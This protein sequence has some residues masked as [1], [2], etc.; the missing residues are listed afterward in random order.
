MSDCITLSEHS[1]SDFFQQPR[2]PGRDKH[3]SKLFGTISEEVVRAW[4]TLPSVKYEDKGRP[5][6]KRRDEGRGHT[7]DF[8]LCDRG[9]GKLYI[10]ELKCELEYENYRYLRLTNPEQLRHHE[11]NVAAFRKFVEVARDPRAIPVTVG[12]KAV[13]VS[14][15]I[16]IWGAASPQGAEV[17]RNVYGFHEVLTLESMLPDLRANPP[18]AWADRVNKLR[19]WSNELFDF[20]SPK[21]NPRRDK[22]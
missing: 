13:E 17:V 9:S 18:R 1:F 15:A 6:L 12:G 8:T 20:L 4:C 3:L 5:T 2:Y 16:L 10:A 7:L 22:R 14:G 19:I 21:D 11:R